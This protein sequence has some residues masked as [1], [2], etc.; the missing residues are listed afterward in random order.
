MIKTLEFFFIVLCCVSFIHSQHTIAMI[1]VNPLCDASLDRRGLKRKMESALCSQ[2][3]PK[4]YDLEI[5]SECEID[6]YAHF[7]VMEKTCAPTTIEGISPFSR[8]SILVWLKHVHEDMRSTAATLHLAYN[9][10]DRCASLRIE[11]KHLRLV[12]IAALMIASKYQDSTLFTVADYSYMC[13]DEYTR[14][15]IVDMETKILQHIEYRV[16]VPTVW[17]FIGYAIL[18]ASGTQ[19]HM[20]RALSLYESCV[21]DVQLLKHSPSVIAAAC[22]YLVRS[23]DVGCVS[24]RRRALTGL[25]AVPHG[26]LFECVKVLIRT[27]EHLNQKLGITDL[28]DASTKILL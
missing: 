13:D 11:V 14:R 16:S 28:I 26:K 24:A 8:A 27:E 3:I 1:V 22:V 21:K 12:G 25:C 10:F 15:E 5:F 7:R 23:R 17:S 18:E 4:E 20:D 9:I 6:A 19:E 2:T